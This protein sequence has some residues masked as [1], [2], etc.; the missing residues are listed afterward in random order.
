MPLA[1]LG[2]GQVLGESFLGAGK[3]KIPGC[4]SS[5]KIHE[6]SLPAKKKT[7]AQVFCLARLCAGVTF[8][9]Q[10][11]TRIIPIEN[12]LKCSKTFESSP[13]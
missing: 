9:R 4:S 12:G 6:K 5:S 3:P 11:V 13:V 1:I 10:K 7:E 2:L 8:C